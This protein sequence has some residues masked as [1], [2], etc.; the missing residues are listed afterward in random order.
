MIKYYYFHS[1]KNFSKSHFE[2]ALRNSF[3][4]YIDIE[5]LDD[6]NGII[7]SDETFHNHLSHIQQ[8]LF[9]DLNSSFVFLVGFDNKKIS[10]IS[11]NELVEKRKVGIYSIL[12]ILLDKSLDSLSIYI[13]IKKVLENV[14]E[15][16]LSVT[17]S[18]LYCSLNASEA[19]KQLYMH[20][21]TFSYKLASF[22][23]ITG[24]DLRDYSTSVVLFLYF[25]T[26]K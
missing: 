23:E 15:E 13:E 2:D 8:I 6:K 18:Y 25:K 22:I 19:A 10:E 17:N 7:L 11:M 16:M 24:I 26:R 14:D 4:N 12:D 20:R 9:N 1:Y 5:Y 3:G 21:N